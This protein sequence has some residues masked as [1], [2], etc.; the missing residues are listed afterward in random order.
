MR[1]L[2][3]SPN[4]YENP[5]AMKFDSRYSP[6]TPDTRVKF[7]CSYGKN[8]LRSRESIHF[9][10]MSN[11]NQIKHT[12]YWE[13]FGD[14][15]EVLG[16]ERERYEKLKAVKSEVDDRLHLALGTIES[17]KVELGEALPHI[18][19]RRLSGGRSM[20]SSITTAVE[21]PAP[22]PVEDISS[23]FAEVA[24]SDEEPMVVSSNDDRFVGESEDD[25][26][27]GKAVVRG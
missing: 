7:M 20:P 24:L 18:G 12:S 5:S 21:R 27:K 19:R 23:R 25:T 22:D 9:G 15:K 17:L 13:P 2:N 3:I 6:I 16:K 8:M 11:V 10:K 1:D 14:G 26:R 4:Y